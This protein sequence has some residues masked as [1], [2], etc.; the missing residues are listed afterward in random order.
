MELFASDSAKIVNMSL[1][2]FFG[3]EDLVDMYS[4]G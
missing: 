3:P 1:E 2:T 4:I